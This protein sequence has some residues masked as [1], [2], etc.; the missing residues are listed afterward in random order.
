MR[1]ARSE[2]IPPAKAALFDPPL[3]ASL[4]YAYEDGQLAPI[5]RR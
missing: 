4:P 5:E 1:A 3:M 2:R